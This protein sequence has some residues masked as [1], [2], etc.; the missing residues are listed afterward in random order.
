MSANGEGKDM[1]FMGDKISFADF[2][3]ASSMLS[4]K[5]LVG[6]ESDEWKRVSAWNGGKWEKF[7]S[8]FEPYMQVKD[9]EN[10]V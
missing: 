2:Q 6:A 9:V 3:L 8:Q 4:F 10:P 7:L 1:L 5:I